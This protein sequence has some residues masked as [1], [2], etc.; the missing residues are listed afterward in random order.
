MLS[1][2]VSLATAILTFVLTGGLDDIKKFR[3]G[4]SDGSE[5][6]H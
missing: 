3:L 6:S 4:V 5:I 1:F 2:K